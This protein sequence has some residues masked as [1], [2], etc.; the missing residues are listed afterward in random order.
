MWLEKN[1]RLCWKDSLS[2]HDLWPPEDHLGCPVILQSL[3][4]TSHCP[5]VLLLVITV[6]QAL[7]Q[8][9]LLLT[10]SQWYNFFPTE[11]IDVKKQKTKHSY[12][13]T[14]KNILQYSGCHTL[15]F[16][17]L[18]WMDHPCVYLRPGPPLEHW[19]PFFMIIIRHHS[20]N[21]L[22]S[23][24]Y[25]FLSLLDHSH[26]PTS[27]DI[28]L[29]FKKKK[30]LDPT[31]PSSYFSISLLTIQSKTLKNCLYFFYFLTSYSLSHI[32]QSGLCTCHDNETTF[33]KVPNDFYAEKFNGQFSVLLCWTISNNLSQLITPFL[34]HFLQLVPDT[35]VYQSSSYFTSCSFPICLFTGSKMGMPYALVLEQPLL[36]SLS[37]LPLS[38]SPII[39]SP[40]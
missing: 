19:I 40:F 9:S 11:K 27:G 38:S 21:Y 7:A 12:P 5:T 6:S 4:Q 34:K 10:F 15:P 31:F 14:T 13:P 17:L 28:T 32:L 1:T 37:C 3:P 18:W 33:I 35:S 2:I 30:I 26:Q 24:S 22:S 39:S 16:L 29:I 25:N 36:F 23:T 20:S 8:L